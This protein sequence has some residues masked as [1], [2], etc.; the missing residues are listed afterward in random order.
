MLSSHAASR[1]RRDA[2]I[3]RARIL[4]IVFAVGTAVFLARQQYEERILHIQRSAQFWSAIHGDYALLFWASLTL[5]LLAHVWTPLLICWIAIRRG[6]W[7]RLLPFA[8]IV[9]LEL[10]IG[11]LLGANRLS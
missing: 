9:A 11:W 8:T 6:A 4:C 7:L 5:N 3:S 1:S 10:G 2:A